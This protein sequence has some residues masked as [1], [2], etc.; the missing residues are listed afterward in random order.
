M[1][2]GKAR[3]VRRGVLA[4]VWL[5][6]AAVAIPSTAASPGACR[7]RVERV[8]A[9]TWSSRPVGGIEGGSFAWKMAV[10]ETD[11][12]L[13]AVADYRGILVSRDGG[14]RWTRSLLFG[15]VAPPV[16]LSP[17]DVEVVEGR[18]RIVHVLVEP[19]PQGVLKLLSSDD[20]GRTWAAA[21]LPPETGTASLESASVTSSPQS[22][23][24]YLLTV[25]RSG[26]GGVFGAAG[27][28]S[29]E[30][31]AVT[32]SAT[33]SGMCVQV[34]LAPP[35]RH[36]LADPVEAE[37]LWGLTSGTPDA[38]EQLVTSPDGGASWS[39]VAAPELIFG[40]QLMDVTAAG[41]DVTILVLGDFWEFALSRN[42]GRSWEV[43]K[44]PKLASGPSTS[45]GSFDLAHLE[46]GKAFAT[47]LGDTP[48]SAWAGNLLLF[49][50]RAWENASP[51]AFAG[52]DRADEDGDAL[53][54]NE[55]TGTRDSFVMLT[56]QGRLATF[57]PNR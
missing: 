11:P 9:G 7:A 26:H 18:E 1:E 8:P 12:R 3:R 49:D 57:R 27:E 51:P 13:V 30:R 36:L 20:D 52:Y 19:L 46:R 55:L 32:T 44:F 33:S 25:H 40:P 16:T 48:S 37:R 38:D 42:G 4:L 31:R 23:T 34:C 21:D 53:R 14:C 43:G 29:W 39:N 6:A 45:T 24:T 28:G 35:L 54:F 22:A 41:G 47:L 10:D 5:G 15:D 56:S 50:G 17:V 2:D